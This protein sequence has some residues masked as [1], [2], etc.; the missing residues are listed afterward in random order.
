MFF[1]FSFFKCEPFSLSQF[2]IAQQAL[3]ID[4]KS[5]LKMSNNKKIFFSGNSQFFV[6]YPKKRRKIVIYEKKNIF[7]VKWYSIKSSSSSS[8][9]DASFDGTLKPIY[10]ITQLYR[11]L[12][13][14]FHCYNDILSWKLFKALFLS[15]GDVDA[16][17]Y[18]EHI[19]EDK[20]NLKTTK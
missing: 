13:T 3:N 16:L 1:C 7:F 6:S 18:F 15:L 8:Y 5:F 4:E 12:S 14:I 2:F 10:P 20:L 11:L 19:V 17:A 9:V